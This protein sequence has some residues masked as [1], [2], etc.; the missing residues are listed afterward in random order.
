MGRPD[1]PVRVEAGA[2][3]PVGLVVSGL[4]EQTGIESRRG[5]EGFF[6][7]QGTVE[8]AASRILGAGEIQ[9]GDMTCSVCL[10][11]TQG[12]DGAGRPYFDVRGVP[13]TED[14]RQTGIGSKA[15]AALHGMG[16]A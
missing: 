11:L 15:P 4:A 9:A 13:S 6:L 14:G 3:D 12:A 16:K 1:D 10:K 5:S 7:S 2:T 8:K